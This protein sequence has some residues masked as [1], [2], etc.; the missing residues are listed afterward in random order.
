MALTYEQSKRGYGNLFAKAELRPERRAAA[1]AIARRI[2][3]NQARYETAARGRPCP[4]WW[5][6][7]THDMESG[8]NFARH[9]HN[10]D[11]LTARTRQ[12]PAGRPKTGTPPFTWE[13]SAADALDM[14]GYVGGPE[15]ELPRCL[16]EFE[17]YNGFGYQ[18]KG[19]NT[20]YLWSFTTLYS[21]GKYVAD[22]QYS[23]TA[24]SGQCGA[25]ATLKALVELKAVTLPAP[26]LAPVVA[27]ALAMD[28]PLPRIVR[29]S[30]KSKVPEWDVVGAV[31]NFIKGFFS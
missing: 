29:S 20:P 19:V 18:N 24:V 27:E 6:G 11:P 30:V 31:I 7:I 9:L 14:K 26:A 22:G 3:T 21:R 16:F 8:G 1:Q 25:V 13:H 4:W 12:V 2:K 23:A 15:W 28:K 17:R 5:V 10:G